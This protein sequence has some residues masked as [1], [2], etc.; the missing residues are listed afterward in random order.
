M[1]QSLLLLFG[2]YQQCL[3]LAA[4][5]SW[6]HTPW[7]ARDVLLQRSKSSRSSV[8]QRVIQTLFSVINATVLV[9]HWQP[10]EKVSPRFRNGIVASIAP[11]SKR[12]RRDFASG[13]GCEFINFTRRF[14]IVLEAFACRYRDF[15]TTTSPCFRRA[16]ISITKQLRD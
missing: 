13:F 4:I 15:S 12:L 11:S 1:F 16:F 10:H 3:K 6:M 14:R 8:C 9:Y 5:N 2:L 7:E